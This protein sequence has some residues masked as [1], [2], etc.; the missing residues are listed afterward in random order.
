MTCN[1][2]GAPIRYRQRECAYCGSAV[3]EQESKRE[4]PDKI[5]IYA[6]NMLLYTEYRCPICME[7]IPKGTEICPK[8]RT[9]IDFSRE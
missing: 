1:N 6:D 8:C 4:Q 5:T 2:C 9:E 3:V 7:I